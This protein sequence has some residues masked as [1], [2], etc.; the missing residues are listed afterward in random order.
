MITRDSTIREGAVL[1]QVRPFSISTPAPRPVR[2]SV[3]MHAP[4]R[5]PTRC[6]ALLH[7]AKEALDDIGNFLR[8]QFVGDLDDA[9]NLISRSTASIEGRLR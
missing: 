8:Q 4:S 6:V 7:A 3:D 9:G 1:L 2:R 5:R